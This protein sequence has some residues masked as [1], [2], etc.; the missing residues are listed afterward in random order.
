MKHWGEYEEALGIQKE[1]A[2]EGQG[3]AEGKANIK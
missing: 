2:W 3:P 1:G